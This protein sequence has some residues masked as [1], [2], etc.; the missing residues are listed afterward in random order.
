MVYCL[1]INGNALI[2][3]MIQEGTKQAKGGRSA[4]QRVGGWNVGSLIY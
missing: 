4:M 1:K 3:K 2:E